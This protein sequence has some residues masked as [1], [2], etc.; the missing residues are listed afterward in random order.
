MTKNK[1]KDYWT[2]SVSCDKRKLS[3]KYSETVNSYKKIH[4]SVFTDGYGFVQDCLNVAIGFLHIHWLEAL[5][6]LEVKIK[7]A[8]CISDLLA[9]SG[10]FSFSILHTHFLMTTDLLLSFSG[11]LQNFYHSIGGSSSKSIGSSLALD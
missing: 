4:C 7:P 1:N 2:E 5:T 3:K 8:T 9:R 6:S 11:F 10:H